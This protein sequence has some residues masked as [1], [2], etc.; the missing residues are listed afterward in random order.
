VGVFLLFLFKEA[1]LPKTNK[2]NFCFCRK[3]NTNNAEDFFFFWKLQVTVVFIYRPKVSSELDF[4]PTAARI[5]M[6]K[7]I[8]V[9]LL[10]SNLKPAHFPKDLLTVIP[11]TI[12]TTTVIVIF[13]STCNIS[14]PLLVSYS[15]GVPAIRFQFKIFF[16]ARVKPVPRLPIGTQQLRHIA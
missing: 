2:P 16:I 8:P 14:P 5:L 11:H 9:A 12:R 7:V 6:P 13:L 15:L 3:D 1:D 4:R 10:C